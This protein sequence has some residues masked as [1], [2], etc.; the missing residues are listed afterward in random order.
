MMA[1][2][3]FS[4]TPNQQMFNSQQYPSKNIVQHPIGMQTAPQYLPKSQISQINSQYSPP[5][6]L[7]S[8]APPVVS[9]TLPFSID[10]DAELNDILLQAESQVSQQMEPRFTPATAESKS[11]VDD[12]LF[13][14]PDK[15][16]R[17][18]ETQL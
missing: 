5:V 4:G 12:H 14:L 13:D 6:Q 8:P 1:S 7:Q 2:Q 18:E 3:P 11:N 15:K 16:R 9:T 17:T 10:E